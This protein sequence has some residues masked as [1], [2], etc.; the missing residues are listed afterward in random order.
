M[1][2]TDRKAQNGVGS[3]RIEMGSGNESTVV[4]NAKATASFVSSLVDKYGDRG[5]DVARADVQ[6]FAD[7]NPDQAA[8]GSKTT[9]L[10]S[11]F[12]A[13]GNEKGV[14]QG[15]EEGQSDTDI[16]LTTEAKRYKEGG[17]KL[18]GSQDP[19]KG[20]IK[21]ETNPELPALKGPEEN[22]LI[23]SEARETELARRA[24]PERA[25]EEIRRT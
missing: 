12:K 3:R 7:A 4:Q 6:A 16:Y 23:G 1:S 17:E 24:R 10:K 9:R 13:K 21:K 11:N 2:V 18:T 5:E 14:L 19:P 22:K 25:N 15:Q 20:E 8:T